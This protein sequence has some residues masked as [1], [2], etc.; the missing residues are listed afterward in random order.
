M[1]WGTMPYQLPLILLRVMRFV[2]GTLVP[3]LPEE[4]AEAATTNL[5]S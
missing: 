2:V 4:M 1:S 5:Y 3:S